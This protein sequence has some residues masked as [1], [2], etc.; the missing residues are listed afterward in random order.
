[1]DTFEVEGSPSS[2]IIMF[3][4]VKFP[5]LGEI[6]QGR[7]ALSEAHSAMVQEPILGPGSVDPWSQADDNLTVP[8]YPQLW[9]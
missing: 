9:L 1:M 2:E 7:I 6:E 8:L 5:F 4:A 3:L